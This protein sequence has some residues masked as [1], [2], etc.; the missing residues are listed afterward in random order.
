MST[1]EM[2]RPSDVDRRPSRCASPSGRPWGR[3]AGRR[4]G[5]RRG[6]PWLVY[7]R[8]AMDILCWG[9]FAVSVDLLLGYTGLLSFGHAAFWGTSAY[10]T[11]L[12][13]VHSGVPSRSRSSPARSSR[14]CSPGPSATWPYVAPASTSPW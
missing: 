10:T 8:V 6:L 7:P 13:A 5:G 2:T 9:L 4:A 3:H 14:C 11:G 12:M 1:D